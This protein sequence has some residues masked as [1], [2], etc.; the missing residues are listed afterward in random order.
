VRSLYILDRKKNQEI[1]IAGWV[2][3]MGRGGNAIFTISTTD[4]EGDPF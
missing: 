1:V 3:L 2:E 4:F